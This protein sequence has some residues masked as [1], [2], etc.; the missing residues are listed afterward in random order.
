MSTTHHS[1]LRRLS[2]VIA[3]GVLA[4]LVMSSP[5]DAGEI[6]PCPINGCGDEVG[7]SCG[8]CSTINGNYA[9][10]YE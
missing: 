5:S 8:I 4:S 10:Y 9:V 3:G 1:A 6:D 2:I 7:R